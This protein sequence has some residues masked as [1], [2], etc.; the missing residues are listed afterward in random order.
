MVVASGVARGRR[1]R[2]PR[3]AVTTPQRLLNT[4]KT[5][6]RIMRKDKGLSG[7]IDRLP[8]LTWLLFLK[9]LDDSEEMAV[10]ETQLSGREYRPT[11]DAPYR[12]RD[13][14]APDDGLTGD[15]LIHFIT[16]EL[17]DHRDSAGEAHRIPGLLA[18]LRGLQGREA[19]DR[20]DVVAQIFSEVSV[21]MRSGYLLRDLI[22]CLDQIDFHSTDE[23]HTLSAIYESLLKEMRDVAG[24]AGEYYTPRPV[25]RFMVDVAAPDLGEMVLDPA[26]GTGGFLVEA[27]RHL[28]AQVRTVE[29][30]QI[31]QGFAADGTATKPSVTGGEAKPLPYLLCQMNLMLHG[32]ERPVIDSL[33]SLRRR[34]ADFTDSDRVDVVLTNPP[35]GGEEE[36]GIQSNFP[37]DGQTTETALLFLQLVMERLRR[38]PTPGRAAV[39]VPDGILASRDGVA[40]RVKR[41]LLTRFN[42]HTVVRLPS[43]VFE[44]YTSIPTNILFFDRSGPSTDVWFY[45][46]PLPQGRKKYVKTAPIKYD[47]FVPLT[48]WWNDR[49]V[50]TFAW[51]VPA[52]QIITDSCFLDLHHPARPVEDTSR[53]VVEVVEDVASQGGEVHRATAEELDPGRWSALA[54]AEVE[55][56]TVS[57]ARVLIPES[58]DVVV[59]LEETY[60]LIGIRLEG[61]GP[62]IREEKLGRELSATS[63]NCITTGQFI[64]S[65]L[66]A[67]RG[68]FGIVPEALDGAYGSGE[69]PTF[70]I[71]TDIADPGY[72][73]LYF[74]RPLVWREVERLCTGTTK[75]SRNRLKQAA[76]LSIDVR[77]PALAIQQEIAENAAT[78]Q[79][80]AESWRGHANDLQHL[81]VRLLAEIYRGTL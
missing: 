46:H 76:L 8:Q 15:A 67:W 49:A 78:L 11:V 54:A 4:I 6:R 79:S 34:L 41:D 80:L 47:E 24:D 3:A 1:G 36:R 55:A 44:P 58:N 40:E 71:N 51:V 77:L 69:F 14:A 75:A 33:N 73:R 18:Y 10:T 70:A 61:A 59:E 29:D 5:A 57:L 2:V 60:S 20:R 64:Y 28:E 39:I 25:V 26:C 21:K 62:F 66:F 65:R 42:L 37:V 35:F 19:H 31:L 7:D 13:W 9:F 27:F 56:E 48:A 32:V 63:L 23:V 12:W 53:P 50:N 43:G 68:A 17:V 16:D 72:L 52:D 30:R 81:P 38:P 22:N 74:T 45:E